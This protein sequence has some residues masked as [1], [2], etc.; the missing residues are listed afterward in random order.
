MA[1]TNDDDSMGVAAEVS[2]PGASENEISDIENDTDFPTPAEVNAF[3]FPPSALPIEAHDAQLA[4]T[5]RS[6]AATIAFDAAVSS[7]DVPNETPSLLRSSA[8][9]SAEDDVARTDGRVETLDAR[10][11]GSPRRGDTTT[12]E[13]LAPRTTASI[14]RASTSQLNASAP[15]VVSADFAQSAANSVRVSLALAEEGTA[16][17]NSI[18]AALAFHSALMADHQQKN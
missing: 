2:I 14:G 5:P 10:L 17:Y 3:R 1:D 6:S 15:A 8:G 12:D 7:S 4:V 11:Y 9:T 18:K 16:M 13:V